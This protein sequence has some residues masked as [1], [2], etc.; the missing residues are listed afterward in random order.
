MTKSNAQTQPRKAH[1]FI[2]V[3][4]VFG[5]AYMRELKSRNT[6]GYRAKGELANTAIAIQHGIE[7]LRNHDP[8]ADLR[9]AQE[10]ALADERLI[11]GRG[12]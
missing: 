9:R 8:Q 6:L 4:K 5:G 11:K 2:E 7:A 3:L 12:L 10:R 1:P